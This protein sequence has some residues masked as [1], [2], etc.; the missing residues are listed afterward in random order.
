MAKPDGNYFKYV[1]PPGPDEYECVEA[2]WF[3]LKGMLYQV[4][5]GFRCD[6]G[7]TSIGERIGW[8]SVGSPMEGPYGAHDKVYR[9]P[10]LFPG[11]KR[12]HADKMMLKEGKRHGASF[13]ERWVAWWFVR[14]FG[15]KSWEKHRGDH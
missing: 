8:P 12:R 15:K 2:Y 13:R 10:E 1:G 14:Q 3:R 4:E 5:V 9:N 7:S 11:I 6:V